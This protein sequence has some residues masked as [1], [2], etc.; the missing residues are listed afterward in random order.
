[1]S[2][3]LNHCVG[4]TPGDSPVHCEANWVQDG[5]LI[6]FIILVFLTVNDFRQIVSYVKAFLFW[7]PSQSVM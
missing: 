7:C 5:N 6:I 2:E 3:N 1:M 4:W